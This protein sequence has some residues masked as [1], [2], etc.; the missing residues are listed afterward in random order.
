MEEYCG[1]CEPWVIT[2][3]G[4]CLDICNQR[5]IKEYKLGEAI[6]MSS[7]FLLTM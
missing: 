1:D 4:K 3:E 5:E 2:R 7:T 6:A